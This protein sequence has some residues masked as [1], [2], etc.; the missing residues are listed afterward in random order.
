MASK[1]RFTRDLTP[2]ENEAAREVWRELKRTRWGGNASKA[3]EELGLDQSTL[4]KFESDR[5]GISVKLAIRLYVIA[6]KDFGPIIGMPERTIDNETDP[7]ELAA[8]LASP[9][10]RS[11]SDATVA[12]LRAFAAKSKER[13]TEAELYMMALVFEG[14][15]GMSGQ[16]VDDDPVE[17]AKAKRAAKGRSKR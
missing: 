9:A 11:W 1:E 14:P 4:S 16:V 10:A 6:G 2:E 17:R 8:V 13:R 7:P 15:R 12:G 3:A 5:Q